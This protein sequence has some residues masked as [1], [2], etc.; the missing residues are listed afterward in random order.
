MNIS[1]RGAAAV[2]IVSNTLLVSAKIVVGIMTGSV[3]VLSE[4]VH[5]GMDLLASLIAFFSVSVSARPADDEHRYGH[6]KIENVSGV[7][8]AAL[9]LVAAALIVVEAAKRLRG[10]EVEQLGLGMSAMGLS[11][12]LNLAVSRMLFTT[13]KRHDSIALEADAH[14]LSTDVYT[15]LGVFVGLLLVR[16]TGLHILDPLAAMGV[17]ALIAWV[18]FDVLRRSFVDL[19]DVRLPTEEETRIRAIIDEHGGHFVE[20]HHMRT[21]KSG[22]DKYLDLHLVLCKRDSIQRAHDICDHIEKDIQARIPRIHVTTHLEP[23][24]VPLEECENNCKKDGKASAT[25]G[26]IPNLAPE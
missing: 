13:A 12:V 19:L 9:I 11:V 26:H 16:L 4:A 14:H 20:Y 10:G 7:A 17:A 2:S 15:S 6:G 25:G 22:P 18:G 21:R 23:C 8:E 3:S 24:D 1:P 5:S